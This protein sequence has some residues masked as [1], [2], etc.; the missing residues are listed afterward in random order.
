M[1]KGFVG[2]TAILTLTGAVIGPALGA[3]D[4]A[5]H[6]TKSKA[7]RKTPTPEPAYGR[8]AAKQTYEEALRAFN[9]GHWQDAV[10]GFEKAYT[11]SGDAALLFNVAQAQRQAGNVREAIIAYKAFLREKPNTPHR[12]MIEAKLKELEAGVETKTAAPKP[13]GS[14]PQP[15][16]LTGV[17]EDPFDEKGAPPAAPP[18]APQV[19][20]T[21][22]PALALSPVATVRSAAPVSMRTPAVP[23]PG[24]PTPPKA[25][26]EVTA[27]AAASAVAPAPPVSLEPTPI[28]ENGL[29][30]SQQP[31][32]PQPAA[33]SSSRWWL[34][35]GIGAV[36]AAGIVTAV[37]LSTRGSERDTSC[38]SGVNTC[39]PV[40]K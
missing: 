2:L 22:T 7:A 40:G 37:I 13:A 6:P 24:E 30:L 12:E 15:D 19:A 4:K 1:C 5:S 35:T 23:A 9:L 33:A 3:D 26:P 39:L 25:V 34:W 32:T 10:A 27:S 16:R 21:T 8:V 18:L 29:D 36:V 38:P 11:L 17:M 28:R 31:A 14:K 20:A